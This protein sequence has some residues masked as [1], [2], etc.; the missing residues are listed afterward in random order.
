[1]EESPYWFLDYGKRAIML[2]KALCKVLN[3]PLSRKI[4]NPKQ[5]HIPG[6]T[7]EISATIKDS[8]DAGVL[9]LTTFPFNSPL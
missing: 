1:M 9:I 8:K 7:S 4:V 5:C 3:L 6:G 2:G